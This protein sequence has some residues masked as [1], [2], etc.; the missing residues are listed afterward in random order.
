M[1]LLPAACA[2]E[3]PLA[4]P[5]DEQAAVF[6]PDAVGQAW[7]SQVPQEDRGTR[8]DAPW[9]YLSDAELTSAVAAADGRVGIGFKNP[10]D[11]GGVD[12]RGQVLASPVVVA[13]GK[14]LLRNLGLGF[15]VEYE[16][17]PAVSLTM[18]SELV[19]SL[20]ADPRVDYIEPLF[21]G[22]RHAQDTTWNIQRV[23]A[24]QAWSTS[25]GAGIDLL[26]IDSGIDDNHTDLDVEV[27]QACDDSDG[28]AQHQHGT[29]VAG[30][31]AALDNAFDVIGVGHSVDLWSSKDG[32]AVPS[33]DQTA[34]G[35]EFGRVND[36]FAMNISTGYS[37][38][39]TS[40]YDQIAAAYDE[41]HIIVASTGNSGGSN[42]S[43]PAR[44]TEV[45]GVGA[46]DSTDTRPSWSNYGL[47]LEL[48]APGVD[49]KT[50]DLGGGTD[51]VDGTSLSAPHVAAAAAILKDANPSWSNLDV[52]Q[53]L[54]ATAESLGSMG[55]YGYGM[56]DIDDA[57]GYSPMDSLTVG[58]S[59]PTLIQPDATC[60]WDATTNGTSPFSYTWYKHG[61]YAGTGSSYTGSAEPYTSFT[62]EVIVTDYYGIQGSY[63]ITVYENANAKVCFN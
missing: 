57:I 63:E 31:A 6:D 62:L 39:Y 46:T 44:Y 28:T 14:Q 16:L 27:I 49:I 36:T 60:I 18:P 4:A 37:S 2:D 5:E 54:R 56:I 33:P 3:V 8:Y 48:S 24:P 40:L 30:V 13:E 32:D 61:Y 29:L 51:I 50:T 35:V 22:E 15:R 58:I 55:Y 26:I 20:R 38:S 53:A 45:I 21:P 10:G 23:D 11:R 9:W 7:R 25:S 47:G 19:A 42:A 17:I 52:R 1:A 43:Y 12:E 59:G 41:G 34:C